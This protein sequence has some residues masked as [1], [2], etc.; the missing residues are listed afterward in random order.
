MRSGGVR[1]RTSR[2][3]EVTIGIIMIARTKP[4]MNGVPRKFPDV[5]WKSG[6]QPRYWLSNC[7]QTSAVGFRT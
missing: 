2:V 4:A 7:C 5:F 1:L 6:I 3:T